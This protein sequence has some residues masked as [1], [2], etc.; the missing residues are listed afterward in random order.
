MQE[1]T[2]DERRQVHMAMTH[3]AVAL[4]RDEADHQEALDA[5]AS[6]ARKL[7]L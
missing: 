7:A 1:L 2:E 3:R 5:L 4:A 6:A